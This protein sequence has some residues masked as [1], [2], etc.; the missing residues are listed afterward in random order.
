MLN[1]EDRGVIRMN[2]DS[3]RMVSY[4]RRTRRKGSSE[5]PGG[6]RMKSLTGSELRCCSKSREKRATCRA[7][8][9]VSQS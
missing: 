7:L 5:A 9:R 6:K 2:R 3:N 8:V 1:G 4:G